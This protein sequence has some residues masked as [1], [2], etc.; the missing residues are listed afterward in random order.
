M[1]EKNTHDHREDE[2]VDLG[3]YTA[4]LRPHWWKILG[5]SAA[6]GAVTLL[7]LLLQPNRYTASATITPPKEDRKQNAA[8]GLLSSIG[9]SVGG[10]TEVEDL[11]VLFHS[12]DLTA[13][14]FR[15]HDLWPVVMPRRYDSKTGLLRPGWF[16]RVFRGK[17]SEPPGDWDA[18]EAAGDRLSVRANRNLGTVTIAFDAA[19]PKGAAEIVAYYLDEARNRLQEEALDRAKKNKQFIQEQIGKTPDPLTLDRLYALYG[20]EVEHEMLAR[21]REQFGFRIIDSPR[22]PKRK[23]GPHRALDAIL[24]AF[25]SL[26]AGSTYVVVRGT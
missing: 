6:V 21:N 22:I 8:F 18:I 19:S 10:A 5:L 24:L 23:S 15:K 26:L 17:K 4:A 20:Q 7:A 3:R 13:R 2:A 25:L 9:L 16:D 14:V 11:E 12:D 1:P